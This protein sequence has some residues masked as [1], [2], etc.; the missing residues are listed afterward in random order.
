MSGIAYKGPAGYYGVTNKPR[1]DDSHCSSQPGGPFSALAASMLPGEEASEGET[2]GE[3]PNAQPDYRWDEFGFRVDEEDGPEDSSSKLLS[4]PF[5]ESPRRRLQW[6]VELELG[7]GEAL[8]MEGRLDNLVKEGIPHSLRHILWPI[9][10]KADAKKE[11]VGVTYPNIVNNCQNGSLQSSRQIEKDL[12]RTMPTNICFNKPESVGIPRLRRV[13]R[14]IAY[15]FPDIGYC[16]GMGMISASLLL[17]LKEEEA[18]WLMACIIE[19]LLPSSY[20]SANLWGAQADQLVLRSLVTTHL[21]AIDAV[22]TSHNIEISLITLHWFL[23][24]FASAIHIKIMIRVWDLLFHEGTIV[25]FKIALAMLQMYEK[26]IVHAEN[27]A[28]IFNILSSLPSK[29]DDVEALLEAA[30]KVSQDSIDNNLIENLR[31]KHLSFIMSDQSSYSLHMDNSREVPKPWT[32]RRKLNRSKSIVEILLGAQNNEDS[33]P[34]CKNIRRTEL[35]VFLREAILRI[36]TFFQGLD[37]VYQGVNMQ[38]DYSIESHTTDMK[39]FMTSAIKKHKRARAILDFER[40]DDDELGFRKNDIITILSQRDEHCWVG[41]LNGHVGW[42]PA[43]FV[44]LVDERSKLYS[45]AGDD[46]VNEAITDIVRGSLC[47]AIKQML[48]QGLKKSSVLSGSVHPWQFIVDAAAE[49]VSPDY[50]SVFSRLVLCKTYRLEE[51]GKVLSPEELLY[52]CV[53]YVNHTHDKV[54]AQMDVKLRSLIC[55]GLNEQVLHLWLECL[56]SAEESVSTW[57]SPHS[58]LS[59]PGWVLVKCELRTLAQFAFQLSP[60]WELSG[61]R[62]D[63]GLLKEGVRD[64]LVKHHLF[65]WDT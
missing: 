65:S 63:S 15:I 42:F 29:V 57:Y 1:D 8:K 46:K 61:R 31:R 23:T 17:F 51:D 34:R 16:Q 55:L 28:D 47:S 64:M 18:F 19:D 50:N 9:L 41:E 59:S 45:H 38:P 39:D 12:L 36:G 22:L 40:N 44:E 5:V 24:L 11:H 4:I 14:G 58:L 21:P 62:D 43:K 60:D 3:D 2:E 54:G 35:F 33:D 13:L 48:E 26:D 6:A 20:Y 32:A 27:S 7:Q 25:M 53:H 30:N 56:C 10:L 52:R 37:P 49:V